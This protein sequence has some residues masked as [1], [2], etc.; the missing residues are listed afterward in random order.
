MEA[1]F[2]LETS[3]IWNYA[4]RKLVAFFFFPKKLNEAIQWEFGPY[5]FL[6]FTSFLYSFGEKN[7]LLTN[8]LSIIQIQWF[9]CVILVLYDTK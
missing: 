9:P 2:R 7:D 6:K 5:I 1:K 8:I 3:L 4:F